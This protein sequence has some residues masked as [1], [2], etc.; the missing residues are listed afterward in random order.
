VVTHGQIIASY[1]D[2]TPYPS[3][4]LL[5]WCGS[6][7]LH[8]VAADNCDEDATVIVT[9]YEPDPTRWEPGFVRRRE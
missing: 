9:A 8:V 7:P 5:G 2:A 6:R 4:L 3:K 1:P